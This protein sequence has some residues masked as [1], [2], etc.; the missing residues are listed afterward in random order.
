MSQLLEVGF[1]TEYAVDVMRSI[2]PSQ[3][4]DYQ[5]RK[6]G[7]SVKIKS[8]NVVQEEDETLGLIEKETIVEFKI[9]CDDN[10]LR[11][12][13]NFLRALQKEHKPLV[14]SGS[15]PRDAGKDSYTVTS[16]E[17]ADEIMARMNKK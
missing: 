14:L 1:K 16:Y 10:Q 3:S 12:F 9:P 8:V 2:K 6:Y 7:A 4:G 15:L 17:N 11:K 5:G 13:N